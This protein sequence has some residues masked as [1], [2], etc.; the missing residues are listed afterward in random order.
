M[1]NK[2]KL[3]TATALKV[4]KT[5]LHIVASLGLIKDRIDLQP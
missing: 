3:A 5:K 1:A 4:F 2:G